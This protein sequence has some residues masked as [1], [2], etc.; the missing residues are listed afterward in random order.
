MAE[1]CFATVT[2]SLSLLG[3][4]CRAKKKGAGPLF[5]STQVRLSHSMLCLALA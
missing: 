3:L 4:R 2:P 5:F 1:R